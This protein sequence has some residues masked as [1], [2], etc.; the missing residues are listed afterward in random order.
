MYFYN[1]DLKH[2]T[3][4]TDFRCLE[5]LGPDRTVLAFLPLHGVLSVNLSD[6]G[7]R[8]HKFTS[9]FCMKVRKF[10]PCLSS[11]DGKL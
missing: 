8:N 6:A 9:K 3:M 2:V 1:F 7:D 4:V 11:R 5:K 10:H